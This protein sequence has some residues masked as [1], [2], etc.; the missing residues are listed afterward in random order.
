MKIDDLRWEWKKR[1][2][3]LGL[4]P[5]EFCRQADI[6]PTTYYRSLNP[7][8]GSLDRIENTLQRLEN[9]KQS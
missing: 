2:K 4:S 3:K 1:V 8:I 9:E 7:T 6:S 5:L